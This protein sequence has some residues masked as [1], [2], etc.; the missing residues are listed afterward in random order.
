MLCATVLGI[1]HVLDVHSSRHRTCC[2]PQH[3]HV[4]PDVCVCVLMCVLMCV[5]VCVHVCSGGACVCVCVRAR[6]RVC[7]HFVVQWP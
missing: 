7:D 2:V 4:C 1:E 5:C 6:V 3:A